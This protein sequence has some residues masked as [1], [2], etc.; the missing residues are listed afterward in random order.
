MNRHNPFAKLIAQATAL[1]TRDHL[2]EA[3]HAIQRALGLRTTTEPGAPQ[4]HTAA[5]PRHTP[6]ASFT[7][8]PFDTP[9]GQRHYKLFVPAGLQPKPTPLVLM[10]HGCTQDPD[11]FAAGTRMNELAQE[12]GFLVLYPA[13]AP[14]SNAHRC[15]NWFRPSD[16][17]RDSGEPAMLAHITR[18]VMKTHA[19]DPTRVYVA[20]LSAG[21]A[22][23]AI[24]AQEYPDLFAA[25]GVHSGVPHGAANTLTTAFN[26]MQNGPSHMPA[27]QSALPLIV[28]HG[29]QDSTVHPSNGQHFVAG[30]TRAERDAQRTEGGRSY[31]RTLYR[32]N[33]GRIKAEHWVVHGAGHAWSG[34]HPDGSYTDEQGPNATRE[35]L[36]FF[37]QHRLASA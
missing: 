36:R 26:V 15:W 30:L 32:D 6:P 29:D 17:K 7:E 18:H 3:S 35:M 31:E 21:G 34:G 23:A 28:F 16:Q 19:I 8:L 11:D 2:L 4:P 9:Q 25:A 5:T 1:T 10:L 27:T 37:E 13:Q 14:R 12:R 33:R 22:M 20:G 24:L